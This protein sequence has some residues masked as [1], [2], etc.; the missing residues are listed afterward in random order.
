MI[1]LSPE[2]RQLLKNFRFLKGH[3]QCINYFRIKF[4]SLCNTTQKQIYK[5]NFVVYKMRQKSRQTKLGRL[6][7]KITQ[8]L[9]FDT[10]A[11]KSDI[12]ILVKVDC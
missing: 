7:E 11:S 6:K 9:H 1:F 12:Y 4:I 2:D 3:F 5:K 10:V 8:E